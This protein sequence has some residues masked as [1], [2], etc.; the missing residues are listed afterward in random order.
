MAFATGW[1]FWTLLAILLLLGEI[2]SPGFVLGCFALGCFPPLILSFVWPRLFQVTMNGKVTMVLFALSSVLG[3]WLLRPSLV[4][5]LYGQSHRKSDVDAMEGARAM[6][7]VAIP[8]GSQGG[9]V[10]V[11]GTEWW[12]FHQDGDPVPVGREVE[13]VRISGAKVIVRDT[14]DTGALSKNG[15][16]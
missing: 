4:R 11:R 13:I 10:K 12:A 15:S 6:V 3:L 14:Q 5:R 16:N 2:V 9:Y 8:S 1:Q 7:T